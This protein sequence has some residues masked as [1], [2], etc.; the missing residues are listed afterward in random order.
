VLV[1]GGLDVNLNPLASAELYNPATGKWTLT[2]SMSEPREGFTATLLSS[3]EVLADGGDPF[4]A[5]IKQE[6]AS[7]GT[8][9]ICVLR[10]ND[11]DSIRTA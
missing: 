11:G 2:G 7:T 8:V 4:S 1:T 3:G 5:L 10:G 9:E 6:S